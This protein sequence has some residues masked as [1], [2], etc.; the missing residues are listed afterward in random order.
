MPDKQRR[1]TKDGRIDKRGGARV[2]AGR[3]R[4]S[5]EQNLIERLDDLIEQ[6]EV[7]SQLKEL[8][9]SGDFRAIQLYMAYRYGR[10]VERQITM[11]QEVPIIDMNEW[12]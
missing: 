3:K 10:P 1:I 2:N 6:D 11:T 4:K 9:V 12:K 8:A 5:E 7:I